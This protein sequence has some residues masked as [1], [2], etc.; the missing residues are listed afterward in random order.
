MSD[1]IEDRVMADSKRT[2][3]LGAMRT[4][5]PRAATDVLTRRWPGG[6]PSVP[7]ASA[8][9]SPD[10]MASV[11]AGGG[12]SQWQPTPAAPF[13]GLDAYNWKGNPGLGSP[14]S[15]LGNKPEGLTAEDLQYLKLFGDQMWTDP[16]RS[17][18]SLVGNRLGRP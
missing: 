9:P 16:Y 18:G 10:L 7:S 12:L 1:K 13:G 11:L 3:G 4:R 2:G 5:L 6:A 15:Y 8:P 14:M 17:Y